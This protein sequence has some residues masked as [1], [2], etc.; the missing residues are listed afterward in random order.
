M[1]LFD[2]DLKTLRWFHY[3]TLY[4]NNELNCDLMHLFESIGVEKMLPIT[5]S[6]ETYEKWMETMINEHAKITDTKVEASSLDI[7]FSK[8]FPESKED[9][10]LGELRWNLFK[11]MRDD[12]ELDFEAKHIGI[13]F[14]RSKILKTAF[15]DPEVDTVR[16]FVDKLTSISPPIFEHVE[17][18]TS[19]D[20]DLPGMAIKL[21]RALKF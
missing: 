18:D 20:D 19:D 5:L 10:N 1:N 7:I 4:K 8:E 3:H 21:D 13:K 6:S 16:K 9:D 15:I 11:K 14:A 17:S 2:L 12:K